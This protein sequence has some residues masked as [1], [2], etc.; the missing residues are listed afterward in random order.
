MLRA[1]LP[2]MYIYIYIY[3]CIYI[4]IYIVHQVVDVLRAELSERHHVRLVPF[5]S[6]T[7]ALTRARALS[8]AL[9]FSHTHILFREARLDVWYTLRAQRSEEMLCVVYRGY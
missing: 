2:E 6:R 8:L 5:L 4:Y 3:M 1:E 7:L 9:S